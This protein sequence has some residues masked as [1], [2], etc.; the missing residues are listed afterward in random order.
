MKLAIFDFDGTLFPQDTL[1]YLLAQWN[2]LNYSKAQYI[3]VYA[4][5]IILYLKYK[6]GFSS[7]LSREQMKLIAM[8]RFNNIFEGMTENEFIEYFRLCS[9]RLKGLLHKTVVSEV[10]DARINGYH[11]VLLSGSYDCLLKH[12]GDYLNFDTVIGTKVHFNDNLYDYRKQLE[13]VSGK[14]KLKKIQEEFKIIDWKDS[15][16]YGDSFS[17]IEILKSVGQPI[18]V[19]PDAKLK[20]I[21][22]ELD[23]RIIF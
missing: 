21:A 23:W 2:K 3:K 4:S 15:R 1:P 6:L 9:D 14:L 8:Q 5:L 11:T 13:V 12:I 10:N 20:T 19:N 22:I 18:A 7:K 17:D 16:A